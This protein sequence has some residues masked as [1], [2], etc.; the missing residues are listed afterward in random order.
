MIMIYDY[1]FYEDSLQKPDSLW[2]YLF[3]ICWY[4]FE[5]CV[6]LFFHTQVGI[7]KVRWTFR[8]TWYKVEVKVKGC[9]I[10]KITDRVKIK[11]NGLPGNYRATL[12][13]CKSLPHSSWRSLSKHEANC[14]NKMKQ[15]KA[16]SKY[17][18]LQINSVDS[19]LTEK[20]WW[21]NSRCNLWLHARLCFSLDKAM[22]SWVSV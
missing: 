22:K 8:L 2:I 6:D 14:R 4:F 12:Y 10:C 5:I 3:I 20:L 19:G 7:D 17:E 16:W 21:W 9:T 18:E 13:H 11:L 1:V 15:V